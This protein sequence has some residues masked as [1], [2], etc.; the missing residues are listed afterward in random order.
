MFSVNRNL[1][2]LV[3]FAPENRP[4]PMQNLSARKLHRRDL[5]GFDA[6]EWSILLGGVVIGSLMLLLI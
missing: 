4:Y 2:I 1:N 6:L 5:F 3:L